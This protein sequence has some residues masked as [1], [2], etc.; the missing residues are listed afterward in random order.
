MSLVPHELCHPVRVFEIQ[1]VRD[2]VS[3]V[4]R[5]CVISDIVPFVPHELYIGA[6]ELYT[7]PSRIINRGS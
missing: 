2:Y 7:R 5:E 6:H 4:V 3:D 1:F